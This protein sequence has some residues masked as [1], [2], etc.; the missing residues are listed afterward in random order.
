MKNYLNPFKGIL[1]QMKRKVNVVHE[2]S[3]L[4]DNP[5]FNNYQIGP[6]TYGNP[7]ILDWSEGTTLKIGNYCSIA[8]GVTIFLGGN[9]HLN[10]ISTY[11]F[12]SKYNT[13]IS[14][15]DISDH[16]SNGDVE[17]LNDVWIGRGA[18]ILSGVK[19]G[20]GAVIGAGSLVTGNIPDY[21]VVGGNPAKIIKMRFDIEIIEKLLNIK[22]WDWPEDQIL[23]EAELLMSD[24]FRWLIEKYG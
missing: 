13:K 20:N 9:H 22:W 5:A 19:I 12:K 11:P 8:K 6:G 21:A 3:F 16:Y 4:S 2:Y 10:W 7:I 1:R 17:I 18:M 23:K 24:D 14:G 15:N